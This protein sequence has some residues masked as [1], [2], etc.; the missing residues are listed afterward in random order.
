MNLLKSLVGRYPLLNIVVT[1]PT[2]LM[3]R[4]YSA[5]GL[6]TLY[7]NQNALV[8]LEAFTVKDL[9]KWYDAVYTARLARFKRF[10]L[11]RDVASLALICESSDDVLATPYGRRVRGWLSHADWVADSRD[12]PHVIAP[13]EVGAILNR[14]RVGLALS[15]EEGPMYSSIEYLLCGLPVVTTP[16]RGGR[17]EFL[18]P[19]V[20]LTVEAN[21]SAVRIAVQRAIG[22]EIDPYMVR[23][24]TLDAIVEHRSRLIDSVQAVF[25]L[26]GAGRDF[27]AEWDD[28]YIPKLFPTAAIGAKAVDAHNKGIL[29]QLP[30]P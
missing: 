27:A 24:V 6:E 13:M 8:D 12:G 9:P 3:R 23:A 19:A 26:S 25:D 10:E 21:P 2:E 4:E 1:A 17:N 11:A 7:F 30:G 29:E 15:A 22:A 20:S 18:G 14:A 16:N 28:V 5:A